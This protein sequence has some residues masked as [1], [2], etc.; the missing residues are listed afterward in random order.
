MVQHRRVRAQRSFHLRQR[1]S[2]H[3]YW[4]RHIQH[5][6]VPFEEHRFQWRTSAAIEAGSVQRTESA[7]LGRPGHEHVELDVRA[8]QHHAIADARAPDRREVLV[9]TP[10]DQRPTPNYSR[11]PIDSYWEVGVAS[12]EW[13]PSAPAEPSTRSSGGAVTR[14]MPSLRYHSAPVVHGARTNG[15]Y[16]ANHVRSGGC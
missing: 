15:S 5:G 2:Q 12:G 10:S 8:H 7:D 13:L 14:V 3:R 16:S 9:L 1:R 4:P 6:L 11:L